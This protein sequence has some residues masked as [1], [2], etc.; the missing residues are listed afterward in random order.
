MEAAVFISMLLPGKN[1]AFRSRKWPSAEPMPS[2]TNSRTAFELQ[3]QKRSSLA[4]NRHPEAQRDD[5]DDALACGFARNQASIRKCA[6][7]SACCGLFFT[8]ASA[9]FPVDMDSIRGE[10]V[11]HRFV[12]AR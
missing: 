4:K 2:S 6:N 7:L 3:R 5:P 9:N 1:P 8:A 11:A 10:D 12:P